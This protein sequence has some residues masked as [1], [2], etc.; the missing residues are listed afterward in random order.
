[1][2]KFYSDVCSKYKKFKTPKIPYILGKTM[3]NLF[4]QIM[5]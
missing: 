2:K 5:C 1:M 4:Q 3:M